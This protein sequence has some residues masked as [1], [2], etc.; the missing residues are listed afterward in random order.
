MTILKKSVSLN[1]G[2]S[3]VVEFNFTPQEAKTYQVSVSGLTGS[4]TAVAVPTVS[5]IGVTW[6]NNIS[7]AP[8]YHPSGFIKARIG[9]SNLAV[10]FTDKLWITF[11]KYENGLFTPSPT[12][13]LSKQSFM[14]EEVWLA[15]LEW[16][17]V[18]IAYAQEHGL[19]NTVRVLT[20]QKSRVERFRKCSG[21]VYW[22]RISSADPNVYFDYELGLD[23][24]SKTYV[25]GPIPN[26]GTGTKDPMCLFPS[27]EYELK[28]AFSLLFSVDYWGQIIATAPP[29]NYD[30]LIELE[31]KRASFVSLNALS[32]AEVT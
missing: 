6:E 15:L 11:G 7:V 32:I 28:A 19:E 12:G 31:S 2:E 24:G 20:V 26:F 8:G 14:P 16:Y 23:G 5:I 13:I 4:F 25:Y 29:G 18:R 21:F 17:D 10:E 9:I 30:A 3:K 22:G 27:G 1:P